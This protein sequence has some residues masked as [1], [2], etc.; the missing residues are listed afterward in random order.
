MACVVDPVERLPA[1]RHRDDGRR[2]AQVPF[3][4]SHAILDRG[5]V[6]HVYDSSHLFL[7]TWLASFMNLS[8]S[9]TRS[10]TLRQQNIP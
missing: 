10:T 3:F 2:T 5:Q 9:S 4:L 6:R 7:S 8:E 1:A